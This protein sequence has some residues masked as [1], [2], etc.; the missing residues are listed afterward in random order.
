ME[1]GIG[2]DDSVVRSL[3]GIIDALNAERGSL[4]VLGRSLTPAEQEQVGRIEQAL[5]LLGQASQV[6]EGVGGASYE[7]SEQETA[8]DADPF[9]SSELDEDLSLSGDEGPEATD[10]DIVRLNLDPDVAEKA[11]ELRRRAPGVRFTSGR[12]DIRRQARAMAGNVVRRRRWIEQTYRSTPAI[13]ALQQWV[14]SHPEA[15]TADEI[16]AGILAV[17]NSLSVEQR[18]TIS[19]HLSGRAFDIAPGSAPES[20]VR[21]LQPRKFLTREG[22]LTIWHVDF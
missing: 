9:H 11:R 5:S 18:M 13:R 1:Q 8:P 15:N 19:R 16:A 4:S 10:A 21:A 12:R 22:G 17:L 20:A 3:Q 14:D 6:L 2:T 7:G